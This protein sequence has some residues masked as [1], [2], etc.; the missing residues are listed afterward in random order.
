MNEEQDASPVV[1]LM[2]SLK[3]LRS[4]SDEAKSDLGQDLRRLQEGGSPLD[5]APMAPPLAGVFELRADDKDF[6]YRLLY[7]RIEKVIFVLHCFKK[8]TNQ[9]SQRDIG[10]AEQRLRLLRQEL[11]KGKI[12]G[13]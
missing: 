11:R 13:S 12:H 3:V 8:K 5:S 2:D 1:W 7:T 6:W 4:F 10:L 9:T